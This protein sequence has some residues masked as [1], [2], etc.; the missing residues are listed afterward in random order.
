MVGVVKEERDAVELVT[1]VQVGQKPVRRQVRRDR[2]QPNVEELVR[3]GVDGGVH[4]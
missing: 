4:Q 2:E 1:A 3:F